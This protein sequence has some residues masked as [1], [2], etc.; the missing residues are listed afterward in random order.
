V[1][2]RTI[3]ATLAEDDVPLEDVIILDPIE[4]D[5]PAYTRVAE[6]EEVPPGYHEA[7]TETGRAEALS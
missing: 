3:P 7:A 2:S 6:P 5:P 4:Q 1:T